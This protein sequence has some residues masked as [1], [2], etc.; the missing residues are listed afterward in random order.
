MSAADTALQTRR[1]QTKWQADLALAVVALVWGL[2]FVV[3][4]GALT[5][6]STMYFLALRF[7]FASLC[8]TPL[9]IPVFRTAGRRAVWKGIGGGLIAGVFLWTGY[10]LQT[11]GLKYTSAGNSGFLTGLYVVLVPLISAAWYRKWPRAAEL[12]GIAV[13][14]VGMAVLT[15]PSLDRNFRLNRGDVLTIGCAVVFAGHLMA[16]G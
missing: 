3:V 13:A 10:L 11:F 12:A 6:I 14:G 5:E 8:M 4:K 1:A 15:V 7:A 16:V 9:L 2:T